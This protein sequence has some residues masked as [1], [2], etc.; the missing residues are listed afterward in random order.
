MINE[1]LFKMVIRTEQLILCYPKD[2]YKYEDIINLVIEEIKKY[3]PNIFIPRGNCIENL[4]NIK[5]ILCNDI[6]DDKNKRNN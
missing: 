6:L 4:L 5:Q 2:M 3:K 1:D